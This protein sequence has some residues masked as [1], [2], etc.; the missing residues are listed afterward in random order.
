MQNPKHPSGD[1]STN[2]GKSP[3]SSPQNPPP[4]PSADDTNLVDL[5]LT[6]QNTNNNSGGR[7]GKEPKIM[8][9]ALE[10]LAELASDESPNDDGGG[11][12]GMGQSGGIGASMAVAVGGAG[13]SMVVVQGSV[14]AG[15]DQGRASGKRRKV[16][17]VKDPPSG[18]PTCPL[19]HKEFQSWKGAFGHMRKHPERQYRGFHKPPSFSTPLSL[20]AGAGEGSRTGEDRAA[21]TTQPPSGGVLFDLNQPVTDVSESSNAA[22]QRNEEALV[23]RPVAEEKNLRFDLNALPSDEDDNEDN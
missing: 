20:P 19:C 23:S 14:G 17:D 3:P 16:S 8:K 10:V 21:A 18:K 15:R 6:I 4:P 2:D 9:T 1:S 13:G 5:S 22:D 11:D 7:D 12:G